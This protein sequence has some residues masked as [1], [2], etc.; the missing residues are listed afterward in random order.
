M[1]NTLRKDILGS[2]LSV[3]GILS[4]SLLAAKGKQQFTDCHLLIVGANFDVDIWFTRHPVFMSQAWFGLAFYGILFQK[5]SNDKSRNNLHIL[6][7]VIPPL[8][9]PSF[10][11]SHLVS[12]FAL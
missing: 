7:Q 1:G 2:P 12:L 9:L 11:S 5:A 10:P 6:L 4:S 3:V 8:S